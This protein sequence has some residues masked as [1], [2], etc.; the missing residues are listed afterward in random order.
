MDNETIVFLHIP[1][2]GG[3]SLQ[4]IILR[5]YSNE[6]VITDAHENSAE[7][8]EWHD[9]RKRRIKYIQGHFEE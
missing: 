9:E 3:R 6:E 5:K 4:G 1:K 8:A 7:I 2:T